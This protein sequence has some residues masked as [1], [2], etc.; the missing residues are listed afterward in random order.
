MRMSFIHNK[1]AVDCRAVLILLDEGALQDDCLGIRDRR[2]EQKCW[3]D[4]EVWNASGIHVLAPLPKQL[5]VPGCSCRAVRQGPVLR[6][7][8]S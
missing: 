5:P 3:K 8:C 6:S 2:D 4:K 1:C 7:E